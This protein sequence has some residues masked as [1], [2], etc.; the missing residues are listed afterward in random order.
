[1]SLQ[2]LL[3][4][5][6]QIVGYIIMQYRESCYEIFDISNFESEQFEQLG[7]KSKFWYVDDHQRQYLFK[8]IESK[9]GDRIGEDWAEKISCELAECIGLPHAY[10]ELAVHDGVRGVITQNFISQKGEYLTSGNE[11]LQEYL[12]ISTDENPNIQY[13]K[14]VYEI[15]TQK[16]VGKP[17]GFDSFPNVKTASEFFVG[18]LMFDALISN[19]DR[20]NENWGMIRTVRGATHLAP[21]YD[22]GAS[23][24]RNESDAQR[25]TRLLSKDKGQQVASY[26]LKARSQFLDPSSNKKLKLLEVFYQYGML[27]KKAARAWLTKLRFLDERCLR[28]LINKVPHTLMSDVSKEFT[29]QLI[30]HNKENLLKLNNEFL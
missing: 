2:S 1:M 22:H 18:Y 30:E 4:K 12:R 16:I 27:E 10:Y 21:S 24:A 19:Q 29:Y 15:M 26:V 9:S 20:H 8:S 11:L 28:G 7:T 25:Q 14:D 13:I 3:K 17:I 23:L 5:I 6:R